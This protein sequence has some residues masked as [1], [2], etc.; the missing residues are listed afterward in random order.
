MVIRRPTATTRMR[1][2]S[3]LEVIGQLHCEERCARPFLRRE[4]GR[5]FM[6]SSVG[7]GRIQ[8][9]EFRIQNSEEESTSA[10]VGGDVWGGEGD[11]AGGIGGFGGGWW[12]VWILK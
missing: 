12:D 11:G 2:R 7:R 3:W 4:G 1:A 8:K 9:S 5:A 10:A 6:G